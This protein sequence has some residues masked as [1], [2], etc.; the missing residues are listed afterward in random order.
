M[1]DDT[2]D[3]RL[4][5]DMDPERRANIVR[6]LPKRFR[7]KVYFQYRDKF[8]IS[9]RE[10]QEMLAASADEDEKGGVKRQVAGAFDKRVALEK[11]LP[12]MVTRAINQTVKWPS[13]LQ[14]MK[15]LLTAGPVRSWQYLQEK[16][17]KGRMKS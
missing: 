13:T 15:G 8:D 9:G 17:E 1:E 2:L 4:E 5:Q 11:D 14:S 16:R 7:E 12:Q 10:Y 3:I 6:R